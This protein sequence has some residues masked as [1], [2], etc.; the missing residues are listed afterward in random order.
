MNNS[1]KPKY[2]Y[3]AAMKKTMIAFYGVSAY[4]T[5]AYQ[6][7]G[8]NQK[9]Q[10]FLKWRN[11]EMMDEFW[12][13]ESSFQEMNKLGESFLRPE[14]FTWYKDLT[15][16]IFQKSQ[17]LVEKANQIDFSKLN[18]SELIKFIE[19][20]WEY[21]QQNRSIQVVQET[22][23]LASIIARLTELL[24]QNFSNEKADEIRDILILSFK[25]DSIKLEEHNFYTFV[26][27]NPKPTDE[28]LLKYAFLNGWLVTN[29][30]S[31]RDIIRFMQYK[32]ESLPATNLVELENTIKEE[33]SQYIER[34][35][36]YQKLIQNLDS[37]I[38]YLGSILREFSEIALQAKCF[39]HSLEIVFQL[40]IARFLSQRYEIDYD[41]LVYNYFLGD[42]VEL[43]KNKQTLSLEIVARR[44]QGLALICKDDKLV[45]YEGAE[46]VEYCKNEVKDSLPDLSLKEL[47]GIVGSKGKGNVRGRARIIQMADSS[48]LMKDLKRFEDGDIIVTGNTQPQIMPIAYKAGA[49]VTNEGGITAHAAII[50]RELGIPCI[51]G[52]KHATRVIKDGDMLEIDI[53]NSKVKILN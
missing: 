36:H 44:K 14:H 38:V 35:N 23:W 52:T 16:G 8:E 40:I 19:E 49:I 32:L 20:T 6:T 51:V 2:K 1:T 27:K 46:I 43:I 21:T 25:P 47:T 30:F 29:T 48:A 15:R 26:I 39:T 4:F 11:N 41:D 9:I 12:I 7:F 31:D 17:E 37:E 42:L 10:K 45:L 24:S 3:V 28:S 5:R 53:E 50:S 22:E 13:P 18:N 34:E 33:L